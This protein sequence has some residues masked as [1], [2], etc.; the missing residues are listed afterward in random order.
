L[1]WDINNPCQLQELSDSE[2]SLLAEI[3]HNRWNIEE[4]LLGYRPVKLNEEK[5]I[6]KDKKRKGYWKARFIHYD[7]RPFDGLKED[8]KGRKS[9][10]YDAVIVRALPLILNNQ[11]V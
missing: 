4:L 3:E 9:S 1:N 8:D 11:V 6:D 10:V 2:V 7:I 5:E